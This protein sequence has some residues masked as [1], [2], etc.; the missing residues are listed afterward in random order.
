MRGQDL[1]LRPSGYENARKVACYCENW[2][3]PKHLIANDFLPLTFRVGFARIRVPLLRFA[4]F[5]A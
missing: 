5:R 4:L 1:N 3:V 2:R